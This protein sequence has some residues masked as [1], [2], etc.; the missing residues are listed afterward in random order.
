M[1][2]GHKNEIIITKQKNQLSETFELMAC[3]TDMAIYICFKLKDLQ[4]KKEQSHF[5]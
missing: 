5:M 4:G 3:N 2:N 1:L